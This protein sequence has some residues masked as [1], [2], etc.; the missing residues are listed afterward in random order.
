ME[1]GNLSAKRDW[2]HAREYVEV[3]LSFS[4]HTLSIN[5]SSSTIQAMWRILQHNVPEDFVIATGV[6]TTVREFC[7][8]AFK[9]VGIELE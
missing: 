7:Y 1:L 4:S 5:S 3:G 8:L 6:Y 2:G 9:E